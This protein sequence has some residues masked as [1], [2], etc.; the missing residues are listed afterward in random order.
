MI[1][2]RGAS[3]LATVGTLIL[4]VGALGAAGYTMM[5][6][7]CIAGS[8]GASCGDKTTATVIAASNQEP[9]TCQSSCASSCE[10]PAAQVVEASNS[11]PGSCCPLGAMTQEAAA[12]SD[13]SSSCKSSCDK[14]ETK[15]VAASN[16][17][18]SCASQCG[19]SCDKGVKTIAASTAKQCAS[20]CGSSCSGKKGSFTAPTVLA[21]SYPIMMPAMNFTAKAGC[22][23]SCDE[24]CGKGACDPGSCAGKVQN[25]A[26]TA[27]KSCASA[28]G[29]SCSKGEAKAIAAANTGK[30][31]CGSSCSSTCSDAKAQTIATTVKSSCGA[32]T[33]CS[34][35]KS[36]VAWTVKPGIVRPASFVQPGKA[37]CSSS[38]CSGAK[39]EPAA[40]TAT[41]S[42]CCGGS[43]ERADGKPC[44]GQCTDKKDAEKPLASAN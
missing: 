29:S 40:N 37:G 39:V 44:C 10:K 13:C 2:R 1:K 36:F 34:A 41:D 6:G 7:D 30:A 28:C 12:K 20:Q 18:G 22:C 26:N 31:S 21:A 17:K 43:G 38:C 24:P 9:G 16:D 8:C 14:A 5:T 35:P 15:V 42:G 11:E 27:Q 32:A 25:V 33:T 3:L 4:G 19:S 23:G